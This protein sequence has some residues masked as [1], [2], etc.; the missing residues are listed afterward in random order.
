MNNQIRNLSRLIWITIPEPSR[1]DHIQK[2]NHIKMLL[3]FAYAVRHALL[4]EGGLF[5][6]FEKL[7][8]DDMKDSVLYEHAMP[9]PYQISY[10]VILPDPS[11]LGF[12][13]FVPCIESQARWL[14]V[15]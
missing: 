5:Q 13:R 12:P 10:R 1:A 9:L 2:I 8:P 7:L 14:M 6:D 11:F 3:G 15:A 4:E